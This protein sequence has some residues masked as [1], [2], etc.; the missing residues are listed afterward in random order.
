M[1]RPPRVLN[2]QRDRIP[3]GAMLVDRTTPWGNPFVLR[4]E[5]SRE[6]VVFEYEGWLRWWLAAGK[7]IH[8]GARSNRWVVEHIDALKGKDLVCH[9]APKRCHADIL[10]RLA[11]TGAL[12]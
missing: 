6:F 2:V 10:L 8:Y 9:C 7:D 4:G 11:N 1:R 5:D 12:E 3:K